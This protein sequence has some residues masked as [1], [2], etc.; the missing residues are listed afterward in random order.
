LTFSSDRVA[1]LRKP[2]Y[3]S[4]KNLKFNLCQKKSE[5]QRRSAS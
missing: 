2:K 4:H 3:L 1:R 5:S